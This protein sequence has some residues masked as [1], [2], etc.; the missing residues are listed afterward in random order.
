M[1]HVDVYNLAGERLRQVELPEGVFGI[2]PHRGVMHQALVRQLANARRGTHKSQTR[3]EVNRTTK[4][5]YRQKGTGRARHGSRS[6]NIFV[7]GAKGHGPRPRK[8]TKSMPQKM[9]QLALRSALSAKA[10]DGAIVLVDGLG[11]EAPKTRVMRQFVDQVCGGESTLFVLSD[12]NEPVERSVR[13]LPDARYLRA[14]YLNVRDLLGYER[15]VLPLTALD[16][17]V[18]HLGPGA[19]RGSSDAADDGPIDGSSTGMASGSMDE[20]DGDE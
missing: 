12:R 19:A 14:G 20:G 7:G 16:A 9:R 17:I 5:W 18:A 6:A 13:N 11:M 15:L 1:I 4:K 10:A 3:S 8:Y 2:D